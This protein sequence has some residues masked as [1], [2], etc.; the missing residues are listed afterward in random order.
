MEEN[1][2]EGW[3]SPPPMVKEGSIVMGPSQSY[4]RV[5]PVIFFCHGNAISLKDKAISVMHEQNVQA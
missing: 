4:G 3:L 1:S 2:L 5:I